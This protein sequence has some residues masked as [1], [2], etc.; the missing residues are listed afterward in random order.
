MRTPRTN[1]SSGLATVVESSLPSTPAIGTSKILTDQVAALAARQPMQIPEEVEGE[2]AAEKKSASHARTDSVT[3]SITPKSQQESESESGYRSEDKAPAA[4]TKQAPPP[5]RSNSLARRQTVMGGKDGL[6]R[7]MTV[8]TETV[9]SVP[10]LALGTV[11]PQ[12]GASIRSKKSTDTIRAPKKEKKRPNKRPNPGSSTQPSSKADIFA[13]K[14]AEAVDEANSS[15][16][17]ETFVYESNPPEPS[18]QRPSSRFHSRTPSATSIQGGP[19]PRGQ[20]LPLLSALDGTQTTGRKG[21]KFVN[22]SIKDTDGIIGDSLGTERGGT[23]SG[24]SRE[25]RS[26]KERNGNSRHHNGHRSILADDNPFHRPSIHKS[27]TS[28]LRHVANSQASSR[29][30]SVPPSPRHAQYRNGASATGPRKSPRMWATYEADAEGA[31]DEQVPLIASNRGS[32]TFRRNRQGNSSIRH[33]EQD[34]IRRRGCARSYAGC[35]VA[36][37]TMIL[38]MAGVGGF[39][40]STTNTLQGVQV[41]DIT[42]VLVS[43]QEIMLDLVVQAINPNLISVTVG[44]MDVNLFAKSRYVREDRDDDDDDD[45]GLDELAIGQSHNDKNSAVSLA[46]EQ[47]EHT[48][49][50]IHRAMRERLTTVPF[51]RPLYHTSDN[52]DDGTDPIP[53]P[54]KQTMLLGR[55]IRFDSALTFD[56][57]PVRHLPVTSVGEVRLPKP[58]NKTEEGGT[59]RWERVLQ[60]PFEL[61]VR[62]VL[63]YQLPLSGR[64]RTAPISARTIV[65][66]DVGDGVPDDL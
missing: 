66:P 18:A 55:I 14:I 4:P 2:K 27:S 13:A 58:G 5:V 51:S 37:A 40:V 47:P 44:T 48:V 57:S 25:H 39:L 21:M 11:G 17:E 3:S 49:A 22:N 56:G 34:E 32:R 33:Q 19:D 65:H 45:D 42:D 6:A 1:S 46:E 50:N 63:R 31:D 64:I 9:S 53:E 35:I 8:E 54:D 12:A 16:S 36:I 61:I 23:A 15:D 30:G 10:Q 20:R 62:G 24:S 26:M 59:E 38:I 41:L 7:T 28:S 43:K 29:H 52:V 60:H